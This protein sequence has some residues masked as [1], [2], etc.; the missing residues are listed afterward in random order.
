VGRQLSNSG[1]LRVYG[2]L[3]NYLLAKVNKDQQFENKIAA[4]VSRLMPKRVMTTYYYD[5]VTTA[6]V[7][8][9]SQS[10]TPF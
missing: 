2:P 10:F 6:L 4:A 1:P 7:Q 9:S 5:N 8:F 3:V